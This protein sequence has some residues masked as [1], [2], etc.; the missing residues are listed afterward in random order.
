[1]YTHTHGVLGY[2]DNYNATLLT[3]LIFLEK[4][5]LLEKHPETNVAKTMIIYTTQT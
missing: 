4:K 5:L 1:M 3:L 2:R